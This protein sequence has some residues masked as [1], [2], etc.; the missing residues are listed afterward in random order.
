MTVGL[1]TEGHRK[2]P[3][4]TERH[5]REPKGTEGN[6]RDTE[7]LQKGKGYRRERATEGRISLQIS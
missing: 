5:R 6:R 4:G 3:K 1:N 7:G 2:V